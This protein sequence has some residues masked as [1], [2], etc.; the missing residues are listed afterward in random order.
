MKN[1]VIHINLLAHSIHSEIV[2]LDGISTRKKRHNTM[3][4]NNLDNI[5]ITK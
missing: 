3:I 4:S 5:N 1:K 2:H